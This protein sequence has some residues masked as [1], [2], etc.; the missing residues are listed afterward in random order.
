MNNPI[1]ELVNNIL[2]EKDQLL[3]SSYFKLQRLFEE[4]YGSH[5]IVLMEIGA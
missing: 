3:T 1:K 4:K 2:E 5:T